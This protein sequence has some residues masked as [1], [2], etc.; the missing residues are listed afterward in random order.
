MSE[1]LIP[2]P[3]A[4]KFAGDKPGVTMIDAAY[5]LAAGANHPVNR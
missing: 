5:S 3:S 1:A 4:G 2:N